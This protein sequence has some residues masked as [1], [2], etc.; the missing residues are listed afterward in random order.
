M[1]SVILPFDRSIR[2]FGHSSQE[3]G[4]SEAFMEVDRVRVLFSPFPLRVVF[5][6]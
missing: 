6:A 4:V 5:A 3:E 2:E 1:V